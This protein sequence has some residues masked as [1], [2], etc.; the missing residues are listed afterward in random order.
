MK[1]TAMSYTEY[2]ELPAFVQA[3]FTK[4]MPDPAPGQLRWAGAEAPPAIGEK[5]KIT[6]N[7][8]GTATVV[9][10]FSQDGFLG[11]RTQLETPPAW[12]LKQN[13]GNVIGCIFGPEFAALS[14]EARTNAELS[15]LYPGIK[16]M[17]D[18]LKRK[19]GA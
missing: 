12:Y 19:N 15:K 16:S 4:G 5:I 17:V 1:G 2:L 11:L 18:D 9:G 3:T 8:L 10:Y 6:M 13:G 14:R 7:G